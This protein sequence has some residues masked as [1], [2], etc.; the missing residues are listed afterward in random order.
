MTPDDTDRI[1]ISELARDARQPLAALGATV[2]LSPSAVNERVRRLAERGVIRRIMADTAPEALGLA[3]AAFVWVGLAPGA[4]E[5]GF[6]A[7]MVAHPAVTACHHVTG[8]WSYL[9]QIRVADLAAVERFLTD[10]KAGGWLG[11]SETMLALSTVV[12]PPY[13]AGCQP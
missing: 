13:R 6:R 8:G 7:A 3:V 4:D 2:G 5:P 9:V 11:R 1:L 10:L 12:E